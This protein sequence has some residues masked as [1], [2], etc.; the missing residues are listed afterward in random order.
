VTEIV[1]DRLLLRPWHESDAERLL[2]IHSRRDVV[3]WISDDFDDPKLMT[4]LDQ[5]RDRIGTYAAVFEQ[6]PQGLWAVDPRDGGPPAGAVILKTLPNAE[7]GEVEI[8]WWL[9]PDAQGRGYATEAARAV[10]EHG[11]TGGLSE[12]WTVM[13]PDNHPSRAVMTRIGMTDLGVA[14]RWYPGE[15]QIM[16][17]TREEWSQ[18]RP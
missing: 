12:I 16:R 14:E 8:G 2:D 7:H 1:T 18:G 9:H 15:S 6:P 13:W 5:A 17:L 10:V 3:Q 11:F 4:D